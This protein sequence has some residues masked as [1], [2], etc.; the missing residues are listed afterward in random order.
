MTLTGHP[1]AGLIYRFEPLN[2][3]LEDE[4]KSNLALYPNPTKDALYISGG[5]M[6]APVTIL[7]MSGR[8]ITEGN[9]ENGKIYFGNLSAG[10]YF[11]QVENEVLKFVKH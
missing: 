11:I 8:L 6:F 9:L 2:I 10:V 1:T 5:D 4:V 7:D 3:G